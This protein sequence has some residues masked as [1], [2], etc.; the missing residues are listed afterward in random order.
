MKKWYRGLMIGLVLF[1]LAGCGGGG[2]APVVS[3]PEVAKIVNWAENGGTAPTEADYAAAGVDLNGHSA[4]EINRYIQQYYEKHGS[5]GRFDSDTELSQIAEDLGV[6]ILDT[7]GD[8]IYDVF[9]ST[10]NGNGGGGTG[11]GNSDTTPPVITLRGDSSVTLEVRTIYIDPGATALDD[12]DG[13]ISDQ[14]VRRSNLDVSKPGTYSITYT[15][16]DSAGNEAVST[17]TVHVTCEALYFGVSKSGSVAENEWRYYKFHMSSSDKIKARLEQLSADVDLYVGV[18]FKPDSDNYTCESN[19]ADTDAEE[20]VLDIDGSTDVYVGVYG[21]ESG[22]YS[23]MVIDDYDD[24]PPVIT[25]SP[26]IGEESSNPVIVNACTTTFPNVTA[27]DNKDSSVTVIQKEGFTSFDSCTLGAHTFTYEATDS[28]G[29]SV[30]KNY[31]IK[32]IGIELTFADGNDGTVYQYE[33]YVPICVATGVLCVATGV[34][35]EDLDTTVTGNVDTYTIGNYVSTCFATDGELNATRSY[36]VHV[37]SNPDLVVQHVST[38]PELRTALENAAK[39]AEATND[40]I[41]IAGGTYRTSQDG[42]GTFDYNAAEAKYVRLEAEP[43]EEVI[44]DG[45]DENRVLDFDNDLNGKTILKNLTIRNGNDIETGGVSSEPDLLIKNCKILNN[46]GRGVYAEK[47]V[48]IES[49]EIAHNVNADDHGDSGAGVYIEGQG[50][51]LE[52]NI[53]DNRA[54][55]KGAGIYAAQ[56]LNVM[57]TEIYNNILASDEN[58]V[59]HGGGIYLDSGTLTVSVS[60]IHDNKAL[61]DSNYD[62]VGGGIY[63]KGITDII[64]STITKNYAFVLGG[65][66]YSKETLYISNSDITQNHIIGG[67][68][69]YWH[70]KG[71]GVLAGRNAFIEHSNISDNVISNG[72]N[73]TGAGIYIG[74]DGIDGRY[75]YIISSTF[76]GNK[77]ENHYDK[78]SCCSIYE[79][80]HIYGVAVCSNS[81]SGSV[82]SITNSIFAS[83]KSIHVDDP[84]ND[85]GTTVYDNEGSLVFVNNTVVGNTVTNSA[86]EY[87]TV[88]GRGV[89]YNN[90]FHENT[91]AIN[92]QGDSVLK[93]NYF[94]YVGVYNENGYNIQKADN[95]TPEN[96][97]MTYNSDYTLPADSILIDKGHAIDHTIINDD[98]YYDHVGYFDTVLN[99]VKKDISGYLRDSVYDI[100]AYE[101]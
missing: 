45:N 13:D 48:Q 40:L 71:A 74:D 61:G 15:V 59:S 29:N 75:S 16:M 1:G 12:V 96:G 19:N 93:N 70:A 63:S 58:D 49:S 87:G 46:T 37:V 95:I 80:Y 67:N 66:V 88:Y 6:T 83:N 9:D 7:D 26:A 35:G 4:D 65:G 14:I 90:I 64:G 24:V 57:Y 8:G 79:R 98:L 101:Y 17:R 31:Y 27:T 18:G 99:A 100:G 47:D 11:G 84:T 86:G 56:N 23:L 60:Q 76:S 68:N 55:Y 39:Y 94:S 41:F 22:N 82:L 89:F 32:V 2:G 42:A 52:S 92:F 91:G 43:G 50:L 85:Y 77:V 34:H 44:L 30:T 20:C 5:S 51:I 3:N 38:V 73:G 54:N 62:Q 78:S 36:T 69:T 97:D 10:P 33:D 81:S 53:H 25:F 21:Y 28:S 72:R